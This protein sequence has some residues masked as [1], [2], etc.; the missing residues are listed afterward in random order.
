[1]ALQGPELSLQ[2]RLRRGPSVEYFAV[3]FDLPRVLLRL[4][5]KESNLLLCLVDLPLQALDTP[6]DL[7]F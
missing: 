4:F 7:L 3:L 5:P 6:P 2:S 1:M